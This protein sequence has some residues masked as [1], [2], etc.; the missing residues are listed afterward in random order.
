MHRRNSVQNFGEE[1]CKDV[2]IWKAKTSLDQISGK[3]EM[4]NGN[5]LQVEL[6]G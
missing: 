2:V 4:H 1:T 3:E 6:S 5:T